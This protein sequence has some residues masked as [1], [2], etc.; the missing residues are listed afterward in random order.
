MVDWGLDG[1][2]SQDFLII[3]YYIFFLFLRRHQ[4]LSANTSHAIFEEIMSMW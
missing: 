3:L 4:E 2:C 1:P